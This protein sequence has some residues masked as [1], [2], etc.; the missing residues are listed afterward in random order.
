[1]FLFYFPFEFKNIKVKR[2]KNEM[3]NLLVSAKVKVFFEQ[4]PFSFK[5]KKKNIEK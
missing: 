4:K 3:N 5:K 2:G 1:M